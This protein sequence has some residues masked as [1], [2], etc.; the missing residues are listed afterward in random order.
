MPRKYPPLTL[1]E[2]LR[3]LRRNGFEQVRATGS[4]FRY[5]AWIKGKIRQVTVDHAIDEFDIDLIKYMIAQSGLT[6]EEFYGSTKSAARKAGV[7]FRK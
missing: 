1:S 6:R 4:H 5:R 2:V 7:R 3:I